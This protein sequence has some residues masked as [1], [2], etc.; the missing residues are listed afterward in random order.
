MSATDPHAVQQLNGERERDS[1]FD[2]IF[3]KLLQSTKLLDINLFCVYTLLKR[4]PSGRQGP[5]P[6]LPA[7]GSPGAPRGTQKAGVKPLRVLLAVGTLRG[8][9]VLAS[10][11]VT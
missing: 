2:G 7:L 8:G 4:H 5:D 6:S 1:Q 9:Q 11:G 3:L 10:P